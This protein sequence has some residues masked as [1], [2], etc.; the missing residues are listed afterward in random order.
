MNL[1]TSKGLAILLLVTLISAQQQINFTTLFNSPN[2]SKLKQNSFPTFDLKS[3]SNLWTNYFP[4]RVLN[5]NHPPPEDASKLRFSDIKVLMA[6]GD[7]ATAG[8]GMVFYN[9]PSDI[10]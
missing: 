7:S 6:L 4:C 3:E 5:S 2:F 9:L 10:F 8:F 1:Q